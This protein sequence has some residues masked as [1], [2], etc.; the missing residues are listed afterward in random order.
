MW[1]ATPAI[2]IVGFCA[3]SK[4]EMESAAESETSLVTTFANATLLLRL[5][6]LL[7]QGTPTYQSSEFQ[8]EVEADELLRAV[9]SI[10]EIQYEISATCYHSKAA[11]VV[12]TN[13][14]EPDTDSLKTLTVQEI[15]PEVKKDM[16]FLLK[17]VIYPQHL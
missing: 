5:L 6:R 11:T 16:W 15:W 12:A 10:L 13:Q 7:N 17:W 4:V 14:S 2:S 8:A 1:F 9:A 3:T